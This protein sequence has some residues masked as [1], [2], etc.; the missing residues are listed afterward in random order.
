MHDILNEVRD[1]EIKEIS[2]EEKCTVDKWLDYLM[3]M[4]KKTASGWLGI[5]F[6]VLKAVAPGK[7]FKQV[8]D[9]YVY[10]I[11]KFQP[12]PNI[13]LTW[14]S[15]REATLKIKN[16]PV[17]KRQRDLMKKAG[18]DIDLKFLCEID[19]RIFPEVVKELGVDL[20]WE[21]EENGCRCT[22]KLK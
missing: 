2:L 6:K 4:D 16:C 18:L 8:T 7:A 17:L 20:T 1:L 14:V 19:A 11:Q 9:Q 12:L 3:K 10:T 21:F 5:A 13:E 15:N 22:G